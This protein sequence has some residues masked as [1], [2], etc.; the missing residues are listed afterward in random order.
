VGAMVLKSPQFAAFTTIAG[1]RFRND[2]RRK[3]LI[4]AGHGMTPC[5]TGFSFGYDQQNAGATGW[6]RR[7]FGSARPAR[8]RLR[9]FVR[10][11]Q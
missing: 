5:E 1:L 7:A 4:G 8:D 11:R 10:R 3:V 9:R 2:V 6:W